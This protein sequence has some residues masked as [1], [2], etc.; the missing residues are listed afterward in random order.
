M[1][2]AMAEVVVKDLTD[3]LLA[4]LE[5]I[6]RTLCEQN[7]QRTGHY[8]CTSQEILK[9]VVQAQQDLYVQLLERCRQHYP[10]YIFNK[11]HQYIGHA[12][13]WQAQRLGYTST[14]EARDE[15][16]IFDNPTTRVVYRPQN[17][18][19]V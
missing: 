15:T 1:E 13:S 2:D 4:D 17:R 3:A 5:Q 8:E 19:G 18:M 9:T 16:D 10:G 11:A 6:M 12:I 7:Q 14:K